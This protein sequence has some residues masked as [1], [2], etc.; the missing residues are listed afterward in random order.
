M[1]IVEIVG[2][3]SFQM[4]IVQYDG[5]IQAISPYAAN[6]AFHKS[7]LP[8]ASRCSEHLFDTH[9]LNSSLESVPI[10][11]ISIPQ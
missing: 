10:D 7:I 1:I 2:Q 5:M 8:R 6:Y 9:V 3:D 11:T 4:T